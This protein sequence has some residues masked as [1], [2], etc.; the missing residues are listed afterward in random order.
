M[1]ILAGS[2]AYLQQSCKNGEEYFSQS[3]RSQA[4]PYPLG[5]P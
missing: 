2:E 5:A 3:K 1:P 4:L